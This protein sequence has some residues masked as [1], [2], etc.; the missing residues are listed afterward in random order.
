M[1]SG[2]YR[3]QMMPLKCQGEL[4]L[5]GRRSGFLHVMHQLD[6]SSHRNGE[7]SVDLVWCMVHG[8]S[9]SYAL[10]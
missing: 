5:G 4:S 1:R 3:H 2:A 9:Q 8:R 10:A 7:E 6:A